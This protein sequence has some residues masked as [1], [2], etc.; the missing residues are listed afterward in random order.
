LAA[1]AYDR[2]RV[3][4]AAVLLVGSRV[5]LARH[6]LG[7]RTYHLLPGGGVEEGETLEAALLRE[8]REETGLEC[9]LGR[10]LFLNDTI[11]PDGSRHVVNITFLAHVTGGMLAEHPQDPRVE[12]LDLMEPAEIAGID[13]RP[14]L[15]RELA[16]AAKKDFAVGASYLG[17]LWTEQS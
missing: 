11:A 12:G 9:S 17:A 4:V 8:V 6:R 7:D 3:R 10:L 5:V 14:P 15:G 16:E 13:L 2:P 1:P